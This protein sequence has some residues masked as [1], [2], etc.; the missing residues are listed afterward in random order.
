MATIAALNAVFGM[1]TSGFEKGAQ[2]I[3]KKTKQ[4][5]ADMNKSKKFLDG[6]DFAI[7][8][9]KK[10]L[11]GIT[12]L[13]AGMVAYAIKTAN[14]MDVTA[15]FASRIGADVEELQK[16]HLVN[17]KAG[18]STETFN[19]AMQRMVRRV[20]EASAGYGEAKKAIKELGLEAKDLAGLSPDKMFKKLAGAMDGV[21]G[22]GDKVRLAMK[23]FDSE[24][25]SLVNTMK[26]LNGELDK[27]EG[28]DALMKG[29]LSADQ[30]KN[31]EKLN[32]SMAESGVIV[33]GLMADNSQLIIDG[34]GGVLSLVKSGVEELVAFKRG[35]QNI[36]DFI[37]MS[38]KE[39]DKKTE[40]RLRMI[41]NE[42]I[43]ARHLER[44]TKRKAE[45]EAKVTIEKR[46][47]L[48][49]VKKQIEFANASNALIE[50]EMTATEK[51]VR[52]FNE[53]KRL[54][55]ETGAFGS[56]ADKALG[57]ASKKIDEAVKKESD[58][59]MK[60]HKD[61]V[62]A[63]EKGI[64]KINKLRSDE[65]KARK[66]AAIDEA[67]ERTKTAI[68]NVEFNIANT[69]DRK[70][71]FAR[72]VSKGVTSRGLASGAEQINKKQLDTQKESLK[73]EQGILEVLKQKRTLVAG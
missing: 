38:A 14:A 51:A 46:R 31:F 5:A 35:L 13:G 73:V 63:Q 40:S 44:V 27:I 28:S 55:E 30:I 47:Q 33:Q 69:S 64:K 41:E 9:M 32:N 62:T 66:A 15:K 36:A 70:R 20:S 16:L 23:L 3:S 21:S 39:R 24:G 68:K 19:M 53:L 49:I 60:A 37:T 12:A 58:A 6:L 11:V 45:A 56:K 71:G 61:F 25:V 2:R 59:R 43:Q 42:E 7:P 72:A 1:K 57:I 22:Q 67:I 17:K 29:I 8:S 65:L 18:N 10:A 4:M 34:I 26:N 52:D 50:G 48:D 54:M